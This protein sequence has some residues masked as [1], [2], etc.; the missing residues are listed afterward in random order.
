MSPCK[1]ASAP[2]LLDPHRPL[3]QSNVT[4]LLNHISLMQAHRNIPI[5]VRSVNQGP[6]G[7]YRC[8]KFMHGLAD[9]ACF[10]LRSVLT[11]C[12]TDNGGRPSSFSGA[13]SCLIY[14]YSSFLEPRNL[15]ER[16][17]DAAKQ[18]Q[19]DHAFAILPTRLESASCHW[20]CSRNAISSAAASAT[21][22]S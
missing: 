7:S 12:R 18:S 17:G 1:A 21:F 15:I 10:W 3:S 8:V 20:Y 11:I 22:D 2:Y 9:A 13:L 19:Y 4:T 6:T 5:H 16:L 14:I